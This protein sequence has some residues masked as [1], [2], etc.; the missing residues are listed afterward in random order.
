MLSNRIGIIDMVTVSSLQRL[1]GDLVN[2]HQQFGRIRRAQHL[3]DETVDLRIT[4][5]I[6][7]RD[8]P[9][10]FLQPFTKKPRGIGVVKDVPA[11]LEFHLEFRDAQRPRAQ[12]LH[13]PPLEIEPAQQP[14]GVF[15]DRILPTKLA[16]VSR[17]P[18][19]ESAGALSRRLMFFRARN[20][21]DLIGR[22]PVGDSFVR[23]HIFGL[24][25]CSAAKCSSPGRVV[26]H[27]LPLPPH[28][29]I[30]ILQESH[31]FAF[32][33]GFS[34]HDEIIFSRTRNSSFNWL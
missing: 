19:G 13:Q 7:L 15:L 10:L 4:M 29:R 22:S 14:A 31:E 26:S 17:E 32:S 6:H 30:L 18:I 11:R 16:A 27:G 8:S 28:A 34:R 1:P 20:G 2:S 24:C 3:V 12:C 5:L 33:R 25:H 21:W 23:I 9:F